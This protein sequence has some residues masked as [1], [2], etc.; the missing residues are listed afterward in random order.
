M[1]VN[2]L[3]QTRKPLHR[4]HPL[5]APNRRKPPLILGIQQMLH[6]VEDLGHELFEPMI[7]ESE[8]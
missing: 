6:A 7:P 1:T 8:K 2:R 3:R 5:N 4:I